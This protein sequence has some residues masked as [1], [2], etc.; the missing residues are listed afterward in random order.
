MTKPPKKPAAGN[1]KP[2]HYK[3]I[4]ISM[5]TADLDDLDAKIKVLKARGWTKASKSHL[6]RMALSAIDANE[7]EIPRQ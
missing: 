1:G 4:C 3:V 2:T 6:I 5:Y 7:I